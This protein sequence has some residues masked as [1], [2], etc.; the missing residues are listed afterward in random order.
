MPIHNG[1]AVQMA[2]WQVDAGYFGTPHLIGPLGLH[3]S[4]QAGVFLVGQVPGA[5]S[6]LLTKCY[7]TNIAHKSPYSVPSNRIN[8]ISYMEPH[9]PRPEDRRF[10]KLCI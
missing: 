4:Q 8:E 10:Q 5:G 2:S 7:R 3:A 6:W 9:L 1:H